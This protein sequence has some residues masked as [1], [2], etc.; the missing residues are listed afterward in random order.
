MAFEESGVN[1]LLVDPV[2][3]RQR[4]RRRIEERRTWVLVE[5][6][7]LIFKA[8]VISDTPEVVYLEGIYVHPEHRRQGYGSECLAQLTRTLLDHTRSV[9]VLVDQERQPLAGGQLLDVSGLVGFRQV[10]ISQRHMNRRMSH[11]VG[12]GA[13]IHPA[14][15]RRLA[16]ICRRQCQLKF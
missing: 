7:E 11:Q 3:F 8:D 5:Q 12:N 16:K 14:I 4:C 6:D 13:Q 1:P 2:G 10:R 15:T 9:I